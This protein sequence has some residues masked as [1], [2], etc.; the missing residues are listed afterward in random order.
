M[1]EKYDSCSQGKILQKVKA[2][3]GVT[4]RQA[5]RILGIFANLIFKA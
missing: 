1:G 5:A 3:E 4:Q 2:I